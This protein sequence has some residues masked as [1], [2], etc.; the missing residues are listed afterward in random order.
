MIRILHVINGLQ[1]GGAE[2]MLTKLLSRMDSTRFENHVVTL[3]SGGALWHDVEPHCRSLASLDLNSPAQVPLS[4]F[5]LWRRMRALK[6]D[7]VQTWLYHGDLVGSVAARLCGLPLIW[8]I[9][10]SNID[11][12]QYSFASRSVLAVLPRL[13]GLPAAVIANSRAGRLA[14]EALGYRPKRWVVIPNGF[15]TDRFRPDPAA[16]T[17][18]RKELGLAPDAFVVGMVARFDPQKDHETFV[19]AA[20]LHAGHHP[21][22][23][24]VLIGRGL[25]VECGPIV[26]SVHA[27]GL[28][29]K[30]L[31][32][33]ERP[34]IPRVLQAFDVATLSSAFGE[35]FPNF[36]GEAMSCAVPCVVTDVGDSAV[37]VGETGRVV[38]PGDP[39]ALAAAWATLADADPSARR[40]LGEAA[41]KRIVDHYALPAIVRQFEDL[42]AAVVNG[43][44]T[45]RR[46][47]VSPAL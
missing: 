5:A 3:I 37:I 26:A 16:A 1:R 8:N 4:V 35:G 17:D 41:R 29:D 45:R 6:P 34:D 47:E 38:P 12:R 31:L 2:A 10:C 23:R 19:R 33:E 22:T 20:A 9:R 43:K 30:V 40:A 11:T 18:V 13:S 7:I 46:S 36:V 27:N 39:A 44:P 28:Q 42:Y 15:D 14:H 21:Q 25:N 24:F 32:L